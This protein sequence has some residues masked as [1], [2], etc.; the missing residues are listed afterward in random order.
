MPSALDKLRQTRM[1]F[2]D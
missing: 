2:L 1:G